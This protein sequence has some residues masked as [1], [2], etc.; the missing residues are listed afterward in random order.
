MPTDRRYDS[1]LVL[2]AEGQ[3]RALRD[4]ARARQPADR[5]GECGRGDRGFGQVAGA[6]AGEPHPHRPCAPDETPGRT[7]IEPRAGWRATIRC[8]RADIE[9]LLRDSPSLE[10]TVP[11]V[12]A[13]E[14]ATASHIAAADMADFGEQPGIDLA[15][16][17]CT[18][19]Q[20]LGDWFPA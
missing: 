17:Q 19:E 10:P 7:A 14:S 12:V 5:L 6:R 3:A 2:W 20:V 16:V 13:A 9:T 8:E 15:R 1:D 11:A 4:A 18:P